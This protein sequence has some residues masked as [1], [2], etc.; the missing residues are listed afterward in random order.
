MNQPWLDVIGIGE[1]GWDGLAPS[2]RARLEAAEIIVGGARHHQLVAH[3][4]AQRVEWPSPFRELADELEGWR[5]RKV[6][7]LV[8]GDP[9]WYSAG[10][11]FLRRFGP[12][13]VLFHPQLSAFQL[14]AVRMK[15][16]LADVETLTVHGRPAEQAIPFFGHGQRL[17]LLTQDAGT[18]AKIS[19]LLVECGLGASR[20]TVLGAMGGP[21]ECRIE[22]TA[23]DWSAQAPDFHL[24]A[25]ECIGEDGTSIPPR[26]GLA[27]D[28]FIHDGKMTKR[29]IRALTL[30]ALAPRRG[31]MLW[32]IGVGCGSVAIEWMR[33]AR[34]MR[35][36]GIDTSRDRLAMAA[37]NS[38]RLGAPRLDFKVG[39]VPE[40]LAD[41]P[42]PDAIF[43]GGGLSQE[44]ARAALDA[45][46]A[47]GRLV[48]N[49]VT[50]ESEAILAALHARHGGSLIRIAVSR[51]TPVGKMHGW[52]PAMP[53]TQ[54]SLTK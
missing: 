26:T 42:K 13:A 51:A 45:L 54:W 38:V 40:A 15:W 21:D 43:I 31:Q 19:S 39:R 36:V 49:A 25:V 27:D 32:D 46:P 50:L 4:P 48:A 22:G 34:D 44:V 10:A 29:E 30:S 9:L 52:K 18:P 8:T 47:H 7:V 12:E 33:S 5:G 1:D 35:A 20:L 6:A 14:A 11:L 2:A 16:S 23:A 28:L 24:L 53:V 41:L 37:A 3:L 17:L